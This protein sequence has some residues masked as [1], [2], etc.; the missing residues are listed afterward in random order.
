VRSG[1]AGQATIEWSAL[2]LL[3]ALVPAG[4]GWVV[5]R[6]EA[7]GL[8]ETILHAIVCAAGDGCA[9]SLE[10]AYGGELAAVV[11]RHAPNIVYERGTAQLPVDFRRCREVGCSDGS[12]STVEIGESSAGLPVTAFTRVVDRR[13]RGGRLY[14]QYWFYF[15]DSYSGSV[16]R[17]LGPFADDWPGH[18]A[19]DWEG[20]QVRLAPGSAAQARASSHGGY[21]SG[22]HVEGWGGATGWYRVSGGSHAGHLVDRPDGERTTRSSSLRLIPLESLNG[23]GN[24]S[25]AVSAPWDKSVY[26][27]PEDEAS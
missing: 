4:L 8:G 27:N 18:H 11:R 22:K 23:M 25:F 15:P 7:R 3:V 14:L 17:K 24:Y 12:K 19:D 1:S 21:R 26:R 16:G 20:Y 13:S 10:D 6:A 9:D 2:V 5:S